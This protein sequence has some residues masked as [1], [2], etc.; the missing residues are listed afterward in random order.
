MMD[1]VCFSRM[2]YHTQV[3]C[4]LGLLL[5]VSSD[6]CL[7]VAFRW[8]AVHGFKRLLLELLQEEDQSVV[9]GK[10]ASNSWSCSCL[11]N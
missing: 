7:P 11:S 8:A 9:A 1:T 6:V 5:P 2:S 4:Q 10:A 3:H